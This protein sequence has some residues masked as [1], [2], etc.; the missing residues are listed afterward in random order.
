V[1]AIFASHTLGRWIGRVEGTPVVQPWPFGAELG[2]VELEVGEEP[3]AYCTTPE[4]DGR[5]GG[6]GSGLLEEASSRVLGELVEPMSSRS[7]GPAP[8]ADFFARA[9]RQQT[10]AHAAAVDMLASQPPV[11]GVLSYLPAGPV[12][13]ADILRLYPW[14]DATVASEVE[15][16]ELRKVAQAQ[17]PKPWAAWGFDSAGWGDAGTATL[18]VLEG[19]A[20]E[21]V[22]RALGRRVEWRRTGVGLREAVGR[23]LS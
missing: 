17:W 16:E 22:E 20:L 2:V 4:T 3:K 5:W 8:L 7:G 1:D 10:G 23:A 11:D 19:D 9:L 18:A 12:T 6:A 14:P 13:E 21:H 15:A